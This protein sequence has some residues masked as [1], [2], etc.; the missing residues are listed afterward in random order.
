MY[1]YHR[2]MKG[3]LL[4]VMALGLYKLYEPVK[5]LSKVHLVIQESLS[6]SERIF[7]VLDRQPSVVEAIMARELPPFR[8]SIH[9]ENLSFRY[10]ES[11]QGAE[12]PTSSATLISRSQ[13]VR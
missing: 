7:N 13:P 2:G 11:Y 4:L 10:P 9:L 5:K 8:N 1:A 12:A 6:A 3:S